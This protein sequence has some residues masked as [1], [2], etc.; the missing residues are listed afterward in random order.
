MRFL[1]KAEWDTEAGNAKVKDGTMAQ[2]VQS[3]LEE[4]K[5]EAAYFIASNGKRCS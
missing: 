4:A 5:P 3:I 1:F 2:T